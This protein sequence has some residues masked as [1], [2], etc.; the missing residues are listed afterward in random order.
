VSSKPDNK[1]KLKN[2]ENQTPVQRL[3]NR[4][5]LRFQQLANELKNDL[6][7]V[8]PKTDVQSVQ[9]VLFVSA[10]RGKYRF[11]QNSDSPR[12][13]YNALLLRTYQ[14]TDEN[15]KVWQWIK[16]SL[17]D[18]SSGKPSQR[19]KKNPTEWKEN[20]T[21]FEQLFSHSA[22]LSGLKN[23][24][25]NFEN[26]VRHDVKEKAHDLLIDA[27]ATLPYTGF[28]P[29]CFD[30][31]LRGEQTKWCLR[32][33][34][35][36]NTF[37][38]IRLVNQEGLF[39]E[40]K[41]TF[42]DPKNKKDEP[43]KI[44]LEEIL[45]TDK[46]PKLA[47]LFFPKFIDHF[48][49]GREAV[50]KPS[51]D[52]LF[53]I[54]KDPPQGLFIPVYDFNDESGRGAGG[55]EGWLVVLMDSMKV[56]DKNES[57]IAMAV[58]KNESAITMA[59]Q[60]F[61]S[62]ASEERMRELIE[63]PWTDAMSPAMFTKQN[64]GHYGGWEGNLESETKFH[65]NSKIPFSKI[66][67][68]FLKESKNGLTPTSENE[69]SEITHIAIHIRANEEQ[70]QDLWLVFRRRLDTILP[71]TDKY[72]IDYGYHI[73][74]SVSDLYQTARLRHE[75]IQRGNLS[76]SLSSAHDYS[77]DIGPILSQLSEYG[78]RIQSSMRT[79]QVEADR[80][81]GLPAPAT[82]VRNRITEEL[83][84]LKA[85]PAP[86]F[87]WFAASRFL[88]AHLV[89][90]T[91]GVL[92]PEPVE[93]VKM[94]ENG[95]LADLEEI[96]RLLVWHPV[97][98]QEL[99]DRGRKYARWSP[100]KLRL[101]STWWALFSFDLDP[102][103]ASRPFREKLGERVCSLILD[104]K[105]DQTVF[106]ERFQIP[107][108]QLVNDFGEP[109]SS[110]WP[111][112]DAER[113]RPLDGLLPLFVFSMRF[114]FQCAWAKTIIEDPKG[115]LTI[116]IAPSKPAYRKIEFQITFPSLNSPGS[117]LDNHPYFREWNAQIAHYRGTPVWKSSPWK[118]VAGTTPVTH[119][120]WGNVCQITLTAAL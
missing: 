2:W 110:L 85:K 56:E 100:E 109:S 104:E 90:Q 119:E 23:E 5:I 51:Y 48:V 88:N 115:P 36:I 111:D 3:I 80:L 6:G 76:G 20:R 118:A 44:E 54:P 81:S 83:L 93:C 14:F 13:F 87:G 42:A 114:A 74:R 33:G 26:S 10:D 35:P 41:S 78:E 45:S 58:Q 16:D 8:I 7:R 99:K 98:I 94:L 102:V 49:M 96:V 4:T 27:I 50:D 103:P 1:K 89:T 63:R 21:G 70:G 65:P 112:E 25:S 19:W 64:Y 62:R 30:V 9:S 95:T 117:P 28:L 12:R 43:E 46:M 55:F 47:K 71:E 61:A 22:D 15:N 67:F 75:E 53:H 105:I 120:S 79:I 40:M 29:G 24:F 82:E 68:V 38:V 18:G 108:I 97:T 84:E 73:A 34:H 113:W 52:D 116:R 11:D 106:A 57:A 39:V 101:S 32:M 66:P 86:R 59:V 77:K 72:L 31:F 69:T 91:R 17:E 107:L 60:N 37:K 92:I